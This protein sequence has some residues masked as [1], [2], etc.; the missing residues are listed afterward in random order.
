MNGTLTAL[1]DGKEAGMWRG[2]LTKLG[3]PAEAHKEF[4]GQLVPA[5]FGFKGDREYASWTLRVF[6]GEAKVL[7]SAGAAASA[8]T[9]AA[10]TKD[11][12]S[13]P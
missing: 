2:P 11:A 12:P 3:K 8:S 13:R 6:E 9:P 5:L 1:V 4:P 10:A 7:R